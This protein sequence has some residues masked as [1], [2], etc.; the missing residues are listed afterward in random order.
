MIKGAVAAVIAVCMLIVYSLCTFQ[1]EEYERAVI[2]R[3]GVI[4]DVVG[5]GL[6]WRNPLVESVTE[7][8]VDNQ[9][10]DNKTKPA[11]TYTVDNQ[12]INATYELIYQLPG[13]DEGIKYVYINARNYES[14]VAGAVINRMKI[15]LGTVNAN[16]LAQSRGTVVTKIETGLRAELATSFRIK[17]ISFRL[18]NVDYTDS[19]RAAV[20]RAAEAKAGIETEENKRLQAIKVAEQIEE[21]AKGEAKAYKLKTDSEAEGWRVIGLAK[22][23]ALKAEGEALTANAMLVEYEKAKRWTGAL[24]HMMGVGAVPFLNIDAKALDAPISKR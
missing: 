19:F 13:D 18:L 2:T 20:N 11:N 22:A 17:L 23:A 15:E 6:R 4:A 7:F 8:R 3:W 24:P 1:V 5:P 12:E 14:Q 10:L 16:S 21:K 9:I